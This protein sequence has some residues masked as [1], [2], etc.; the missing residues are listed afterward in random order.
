MLWS[1]YWQTTIPKQ[2][3][4]IFLEH[5]RKKGQSGV[6]K[7]KLQGMMINKIVVFWQTHMS[8]YLLWLTVFQPEISAWGPKWPLQPIFW[9]QIFQEKGQCTSIFLICKR[10]ETVG[11]LRKWKWQFIW[12]WHGASLF[13]HNR[14]NLR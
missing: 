8:W 2:T 12:S 11:K 6:S 5:V 14:G 10:E 7:T 9:D 1:F 4:E 3:P 13:I